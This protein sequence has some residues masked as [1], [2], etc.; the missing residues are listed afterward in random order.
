MNSEHY[1]PTDKFDL[2]TSLVLKDMP[3]EALKLLKRNKTT[4]AYRKGQVIFR[5]NS[6]PAGIYLLDKG[7]AK[8]YKTDNKGNEHIIYI[9]APGDIMGLQSVLSTERYLDSAATLTDSEIT[10]IPREDFLEAVDQSPELAGKLLRILSHEFGVL[11]NTL[12]VQAQKTA[13]EKLAINL[14]SLR[15]KFRGPDDRP[16]DEVSI[17]ISRSDLAGMTGATRESVV[18]LL[19]ELKAAHIVETSGARITIRKYKDLLEIAGY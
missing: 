13:K 2:N 1:F 12:S 10:F 14:I 5:E 3:A 16:E 18:R 4:H 15:E 8:K 6:F 17:S 9:C 19:G 11:T 7:M